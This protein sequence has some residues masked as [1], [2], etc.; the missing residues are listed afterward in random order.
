MCVCVCV[1]ACAFVHVRVRVLV[2]AGQWRCRPAHITQLNPVLSRPASPPS[3]LKSGELTAAEARSALPT[4]KAAGEVKPEDPK[5]S[6]LY[7]TISGP[8][9]IGKRCVGEPRVS[10]PSPTPPPTPNQRNPVEIAALPTAE[11][12]L[13]SFLLLATL[14]TCVVCPVPA[15]CHLLFVWDP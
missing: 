9:G 2:G 5:C 10:P 3:G 14:C 12:V 4:L 7:R 6:L 1:C 11:S 15:S 13:P 8:R